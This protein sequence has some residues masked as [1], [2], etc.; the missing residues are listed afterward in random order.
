MKFLL[1]TNNDT[2]GIGQTV[3]NLSYNLNIKGHSSKI[4][5]LHKFTQNKNI[6]KIKR[7]LLSRI[8]SYLFNFLKNDFNELFWFNHTTIVYSDI[9]KYIDTADVI[10]LFTFHKIISSQIL[11]KILITKKPVF[12]RPLDM[13]MIAGGCHFNL[14]CQKYISSCRA[15]PKI[16]FNKISKFTSNNLIIKKKI[17][18]KFKPKIIAQNDYVKK[19]LE[20]SSVFKLLKSHKIP[21]GVNQNRSKFYTKKKARNLLGISQKEKIIL[22]ATYN[23]A[24]YSKGGHLL[25]KSLEIFEKKYLNKI[26]KNKNIDLRLITLGHKNSFTI[27]LNK[28]KWSH[29]GIVSS[30]SQLNLYYRSA[31]VLI[32]PSLYDFGPHVVNESV[33]N[34]LP[35]IA[36]EVGTAKDVIVNNINGFLV[37][38]YDTFKLASCLKKIFFNKN[39]FK[40][41]N[42]KKKIKS[43]R[44][45]DYEAESFIKLSKNNIKKR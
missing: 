17:I 24:S 16:K 43:F 19:L 35:V 5:T 27:N 4:V 9:K 34:D 32:S 31:D 29:K 39:N 1:I 14:G 7:S 15:C 6:V 18:N 2:D 36:F 13:E 30:D 44:H 42:L 11:E 37:P 22:F 12:L 38:C 25:K 45:S 26:K 21:V 20:R 23:L 8:I 40:N 28:I 41:N 3:T 33:L 10:I